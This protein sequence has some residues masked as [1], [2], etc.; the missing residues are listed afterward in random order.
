MALRESRVVLGHK[1]VNLW[2][3]AIVLVA[4]FV[5][6]LELCSMGHIHMTRSE[7]DIILEFLGG[8]TDDIL[9]KISE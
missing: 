7:D 6:I 1:Y 8:D 5:S 4:T 2:L 3:L 9:K